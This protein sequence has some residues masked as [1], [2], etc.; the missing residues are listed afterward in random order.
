MYNIKNLPA[1]ALLIISTTFF[2][3]TIP[4]GL[5]RILNFFNINNTFS[6]DGTNCETIFN[7]ILKINFEEGL[8]LI[9][10]LCIFLSLIL[11][12]RERK[13]ITTN[14]QKANIVF[15][16]YLVCAL[17]INI[18]SIYALYEDFVD[19]NLL[20]NILN[21]HI[22]FF[23]SFMLIIFN[24]IV[25]F[26]LLSLLIW[27]DNKLTQKNKILLLLFIFVVIFYTSMELSSFIYMWGFVDD[28]ETFIPI[29]DN[30][31]S[32]LGLGV[33]CMNDQMNPCD[34][35]LYKMR[36]ECKNNQDLSQLPRIPRRPP[37][38]RFFRNI[39]SIIKG[40]SQARAAYKCSE[41]KKEYTD[42]MDMFYSQNNKSK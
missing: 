16:I 8:F 4:T 1:Y 40:T 15:F 23:I 17:I 22:L 19:N 31:L 20:L 10:I 24:N 36:H 30:I 28:T 5:H 13:Y 3:K 42:C 7:S 9:S 26:T 2:I 32:N 38:A 39:I 29:F 35:F 14:K 25:I 11:I 34:K 37:N 12:L 21:R 6:I 18:I 33:L 27:F 41:A